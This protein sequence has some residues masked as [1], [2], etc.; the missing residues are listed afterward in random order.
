MN[1]DRL[2]ALRVRRVSAAVL[3]GAGLGLMPALMPGRAL[4]APGSGPPALPAGCSQA[5]VGGTVSCAYGSTGAEQTFPVPSGVTSVTA[6]AVGAAGGSG[7][8]NSGGA[9]GTAEATLDVTGDSTLYVEVGGVGQS[10]DLQYDAGAGG[11]N[12]GGPGGTGADPYGYA[13]AG[14]GGASDVRTE[15]ATAA[16]SL[17]SRLLVA[18][19]AGGG[20]GYASGSNG[21]NAG[22]AGSTTN[23]FAGAGQAGTATNGG[24]GG[25]GSFRDYFPGTA[26]VLGL[27]GTGGAGYTDPSQGV[28]DDGGGGGGAGLYG[29]GGGSG[30]AGGGGGSSYAPGGTTGVD[31]S[32]AGPSV[33]ISYQPQGPAAYLVLAPASATV[34]AGQSEAFTAVDYNADGASLGDVTASTAFSI[35]AT[36]SCSANSCSST[37]A[38]SYTVTGTYG[39]VTATS[40]L[41]VTPA[42][43]SVVTASAGNDQSTD[44]GQ[45]FA[46]SL[47]ATV[48]DQYGNP[49]P[50][51]TVTFA[52][53]G[54]DA[55]F[56]GGTSTASVATAADGTA[57]APAL[58]AGTSGGPLTVTATD[59]A[60]NASATFDLTIDQPPAF[61][62]ADSTTLAVGVHASFAVIASGFPAPTLSES[63]TLP[64]GVSFDPTTG[65]LSGTP[66][67]GAGGRYAL[68]LKATN[69]IAPDATQAFVLTV[70]QAPAFTSTG[71]ATFIV[72]V[73]SSFNVV[74]TGFPSPTLTESG[75]LPAGLTFVD[76]HDGT[77]TLSGTATAGSAGTYRLTIDAQNTTTDPDQSFVLTVNN[78]ASTPTA[79]AVTS[80][81]VA[82]TV[83][84]TAA[85]PAAAPVAA[86]PATASLPFTGMN[87]LVSTLVGLSL[88]AVGALA[89]LASR[90]RRT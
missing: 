15:T 85:S 72:G 75:R 39:Q 20:A 35:S 47:V 82:A 28:A 71:S 63:G 45:P 11:F 55:S 84:A 43:A 9:G 88:L 59:A 56:A 80:A 58:T 68:T 42:A 41:T 14:G 2:R 23:G 27:G 26:G 73:R 31:T 90:R 38:G 70:D 8:L 57:T 51:E 67:Q 86:A 44:V 34:E 7:Y 54:G 69:G 78:P 37:Q 79:T 32:G 52:V 76:H 53:T 61:T 40:T 64:Q 25:V 33:T 6:A 22:Q 17:S 12:G 49:V 77:A 60:A 1:V 24:A 5:Q 10:V 46:T 30:D 21:G 19:G 81:T 65:L 50:G 3:I 89:L 62:S 16:D 4:G 18:A 36:G 13:G 83:T 29:G 87:A 66:A 74:A 48:T